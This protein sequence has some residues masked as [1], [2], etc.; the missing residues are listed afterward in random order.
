MKILTYPNENLRKKCLPF[1]GQFDESLQ[2]TIKKMLAIMKK[3]NGIGL[4][5][6]Q[7]GLD[8]CLTV[9]DL[10]PALARKQTKKQKPIILINPE[11]IKT[12]QKIIKMEE[13]CL[14]L[15]NLYG[16]VQRPENIKV[17]YQN[18]FGKKI[19]LKTT[20][21]L[22]RVI[23]HEF[24]HLQGK[25]FIDQVLPGTLKEIT[26][27]Q[28]CQDLN[29]IFI[30]TSKFGL[31]TLE[32][33]IKNKIIPKLIITET[34]KR[35]GRGNILIFSPVK[36][37]AQKFRLPLISS[38][39]IASAFDEIKKIK[40]DLIIVAAFGQIIPKKILNIPK[41]GTINIH[42]SLLP[43]YRGP[44][45]I[46]SAILRH[47]QETGLSIILMDEKIDHGP[48][49]LQKKIKIDDRVNTPDLEIRLA[50]I[51][52]EL[53][54]KAVKKIANG[55][56]SLKKQNKKNVSYTQKFTK[57][58]GKIDWQDSSEK[59][60]AQVRALKPWPGTYTEIN[61]KRLIIH[62][63]HLENGNLIIDKV[64]P[65]GKNEMSFSDFLRGAPYALDFFKKIKYIG[66]TEKL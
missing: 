66:N 51:G 30:G 62:E 43:K 10:N 11:I 28:I 58:N 3:N 15:P 39:K 55:P 7:V 53:A 57:E 6:N 65:A 2:K 59:I 14:S 32:T 49:I 52:A 13:G 4:S 34:D 27:D 29:I 38:Q 23:Q 41:L 21:I 56:I 45:P 37:Y 25:L 64:Q 40:P 5:A 1:E 12:S 8:F 33:L 26:P 31:P 48:I 35:A 22:A 50:Q 19:T 54:L 47:E 61:G 46:A 9:I 17:K 20:G 44:T 60:D 16:E 36:E 24:D 42:P 63:A 18:Q